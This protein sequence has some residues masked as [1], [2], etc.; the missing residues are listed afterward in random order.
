VIVY[1][2]NRN[3]SLEYKDQK[4]F[5]GVGGAYGWQPYHLHVPIVLKSGSLHVQEKT[6]EEIRA[7]VGEEGKYQTVRGIERVR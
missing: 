2:H 4:Y 1:E 5:L 6:G 3:V 7:D